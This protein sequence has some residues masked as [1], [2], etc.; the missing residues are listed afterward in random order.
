M[1]VLSD[2]DIRRELEREDGLRITPLLDENIQP[3]SVDLTLG[4]QFAEMDPWYGD[5]HGYIDPAWIKANRAK[6]RGIP[7]AA[8]SRIHG[9][10]MLQPNRLVLATTR[11]RVKIPNN[12]VGRVE[13]KSSLGRIGLFIH[14]TAGYIDPGFVGQITLELYSVAQHPIILRP[15]MPFCQLSLIVMS[16]P[17]LRPY[18]HKELGSTY[19]D[20]VGVTGPGRGSVE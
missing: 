18:G 7:S 11:E 1:A 10:F 8:P 5:T 16:S 19:Q 12:L 15:G 6:L 13:G 2:G 14:V 20:Q 4:D 9:G 17:A 3:A